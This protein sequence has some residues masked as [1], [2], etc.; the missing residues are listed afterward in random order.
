VLGN[1]NGQ[2]RRREWLVQNFC[3][4]VE[5]AC[6]TIATFCD[7]TLGQDQ[8]CGIEVARAHPTDL[9]CTHDAAFFQNLEVL[10]HRRKRY[11]KW[12]RQLTHRCRTV[13]EPVEDRTPRGV[14]ERMEN[15]IDDDF[16]QHQLQHPALTAGCQ[17][18]F[19]AVRRC[20][21]G[22][23]APGRVCEKMP[24]GSA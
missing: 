20:V 18:P 5:A 7:P 2:G 19:Y 22:P 21:T 4:T 9:L 13:A 24:Q 3:Q 17:S 14:A 10:H 15:A 12:P 8:P 23:I 16:V 11:R 6:P 1:V